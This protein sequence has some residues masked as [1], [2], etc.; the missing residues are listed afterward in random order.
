MSLICTPLGNEQSSASLIASLFQRFDEPKMSGSQ[1]PKM[2]YYALY[3]LNIR[4]I[5]IHRY[6]LN[7]SLAISRSLAAPA[8]SASNRARFW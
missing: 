2:C 4:I 7:R 1:F 3:K 8:L 6:V 5:R